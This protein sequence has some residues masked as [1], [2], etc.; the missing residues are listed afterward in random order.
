MMRRQG[1]EMGTPIF[2]AQGARSIIVPSSKAFKRMG[3]FHVLPLPYESEHMWRCRQSNCINRM[4]LEQGPHSP[5]AEQS[6]SVP[7]FQTRN[8]RDSATCWVTE[9]FLTDLCG[10]MLSGNEM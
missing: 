7:R 5:A 1:T 2:A 10:E 9:A 8:L 4:S 6:S 3:I